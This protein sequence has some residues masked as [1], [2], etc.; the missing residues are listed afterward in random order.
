MGTS[1]TSASARRSTRTAS[2]VSTEGSF[3]AGVDGAQPGVVMPAQPAPGMRYRQ[4]YYAGH[5][6]DRASILSLDEQV[7]VP[8]G[9]YRH[10]LLDARDQPDRAPGLEYK[11]F[12]RGVGPVL[13]LEVSGGDGR[14]ELLRMRRGG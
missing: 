8:A 1:G 13:A 6:E 9:H 3:E 5:A 11:L 4:E 7:T 2:P 12:A 10:V 14:E